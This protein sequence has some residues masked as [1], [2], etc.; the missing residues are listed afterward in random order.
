M[1]LH[2]FSVCILKLFIVIF[3][4]ETYMDDVWQKIFNGKVHSA[5]V[6][7]LVLRL[8]KYLIVLKWIAGIDSCSA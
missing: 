6:S 3:S 1:H 2:C 7:C 8:A 4:I 5:T